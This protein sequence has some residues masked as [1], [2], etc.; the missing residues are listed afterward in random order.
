MISEQ[1]AKLEFVAQG[2]EEIAEETHQR[3]NQIHEEIFD[4]NEQTEEALFTAQKAV[5][6]IDDLT[7]ELAKERQRIKDLEAQIERN[8]QETANAKLEAELANLRID[9]LLKTQQLADFTEHELIF[10]KLKKTLQLKADE[11][12][13]LAQLNLLHYAPTAALHEETAERE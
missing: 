10:N 9:S 8:K 11:A 7:S 5:H 2:M 3:I 13:L 4:L 1:A 12:K 6:K